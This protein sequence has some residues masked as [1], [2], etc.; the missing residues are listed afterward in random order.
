MA[1]LSAAGEPL[2]VACIGDSITFGY[3][4]ANRERD[5]YPSQLQRMLD[6]APATA[7]KYIVRNFGNSGRGIYL[8]TWRTKDSR[9]GYRYM[10][11]HKQALEW[12]PDIVICNLGI[13][14]CGEYIKELNGEIP[15]GT[16]ERDYAELLSDYAALESKPRFFIW[17]RLAPLAPGQKFYDSIEP[18]MMERDLEAVAKRFNAREMD[19]QEPLRDMIDFAFPDR[20]H[21]NA[22]GAKTIAQET[23]I[24][25]T[26]PA[27]RPVEIPS[28]IAGEC[29]TWLA[30]GQSNMWWPLGSCSAAAKAETAGFA[31]VDVRIWNYFSGIWTKVTPQNA[32]SFGAY[33]ILFAKRRAEKTGKP[34]AILFVA[35]GGAPT[36]SFLSDATLCRFP[37]LAKIATDRHQIDKNPAFPCTWCA[38]EYPKR[39]NTLWEGARW[40]IGNLYRFGIS[41]VN[42]I[43]YTGILWYQGESNA[44]TCVNPDTPTDR[45]YMEETLRAIVAELRSGINKEAPF[46]MTGLP[47]MNRPWE[48]YREAQKKICAETGAIYIDTFA[49]G[50]G[51]P[52]NVHPG[53][54]HLFADLAAEKVE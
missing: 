22:A 37:R 41:R 3:G 47:K 13:N 8:H 4:L 23:F 42:H 32:T 51:E 21:P 33:P 20:I 44:T 18:F 31:N 30:A 53:D 16:F 10:P 26:S 36:E 25:L 27:P 6:E 48:A 14:D 45:E 9:R 28:D 50:L 43:P 1:I 19:M 12:K 52:N 34:V 7:G 40:G 38:R 39:K 54:K 2:K 46:L 35:A 17:T 24:A 15:E 11:E 49:A 29:E 5:A